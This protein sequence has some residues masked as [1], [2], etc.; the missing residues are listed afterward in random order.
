MD[1]TRAE[2]NKRE[3]EQMNRS[4]AWFDKHYSGMK[5]KR[6]IIHPSGKIESAAAFTHDVEGVREADLKRLVKSVRG[7]FKGFET[8]N[9]NDLSESYIQNLLNA[10][11]LSV[12]DLLSKYSRRLKDVK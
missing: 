10:H 11:E 3:A 1:V 7:F 12:S 4:S 8:Q 5:V 6:L 9:L 2:I